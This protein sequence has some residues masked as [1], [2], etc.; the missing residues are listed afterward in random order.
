M[1]RSINRRNRTSRSA[2][3]LLETLCA[4]LIGLLTG[5]ALL[6]V[7]QLTMTVRTSTMGPDAADTESRRQLDLLSDRLRNAQSMTS[8]TSKVVF[9]AASASDLTIYSDTSGSTL[10]LWLNTSVSPAALE[11]TTTISGTATTTVILSGVS[12]LQ[13]TYYEQPSTS[14]TAASSTWTTTANPN[15]P[16]STELPNIGAVQIN[17]TVTMNNYSRQLYT[18]VRLRNSPL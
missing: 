1:G 7:L 2:M 3:I 15:A 12:A 16:A 5:A 6:S 10:R 11:Q 9:T 18:M 17:L 4:L 13:F 8:G 14:Y